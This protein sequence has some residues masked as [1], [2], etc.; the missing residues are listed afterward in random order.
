MGWHSTSFGLANAGPSDDCGISCPTNSPPLHCSGFFLPAQTLCGPCVDPTRAVADALRYIVVR[1]T[2]AATH[3]R[4]TAQHLQ[5]LRAAGVR[6]CYG[7]SAVAAACAAVRTA[8][9]KDKRRRT[10]AYYKRRRTTVFTGAA[11]RS[12]TGAREGA[13]HRCDNKRAARRCSAAS[14]HD[15]DIPARPRSITSRR[16]RH[17]N[18]QQ[19]PRHDT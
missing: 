18:V 7:T 14:R 15:D 3:A 17:A 12:R 11:M 8:S 9:T 13:P 6:R 10:R 4:Y 19:G 5:P 1:V 16:P 2:R